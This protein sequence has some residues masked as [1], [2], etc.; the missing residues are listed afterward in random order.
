MN[1]GVGLMEICLKHQ[2]QELTLGELKL[3]F[4]P[5]VFIEYC[6]ACQYYSKIWT[7]PPYDF[8]LVEMLE[9][10]QYAYIIGS[11]LYVND[12]GKDFNEMLDNKDLEAV[13]NE[14]YI[15]ARK[16]LDKK[17]DA[18]NDQGKHMCVLLAGRCLE[19]D[20]CTREKQL[21]CTY[22]AKMHLSLESMGF[23][24]ASLCEDILGDKIL[25]TKE[26]LPEYIILVSAIL[27][28][29]K[30]NMKDLLNPL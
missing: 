17:L 3:Y 22:P 21:P 23:D 11:K 19:C 13:T 15:A 28:Q 30:L 27:S 8:D 12:L 14:I 10:Y 18:M 7:C 2:I 9:S 20:C 26:S 5:K 25:W 29:E 1:R 24:V 16:A 6:K 4:R